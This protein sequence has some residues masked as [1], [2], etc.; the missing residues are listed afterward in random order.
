MG[1]SVRYSSELS[2]HEDDEAQ[3]GAAEMRLPVAQRSPSD[4]L[5]PGRVGA[6]GPT[7]RHVVRLGS[8]S[9]QR[10]NLK[11]GADRME[12]APVRD[13]PPVLRSGAAAH[14]GSFQLRLL[15]FRACVQ[16]PQ[17]RNGLFGHR[18]RRRCRVWDSS[19]HL[20][21]SSWD[22]SFKARGRDTRWLFGNCVH[23]QSGAISVRRHAPVCTSRA[24]LEEGLDVL[25]GRPGLRARRRQ[26]FAE[27]STS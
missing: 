13:R 26:L 15:R 11:Q 20:G 25:G 7:A 9:W 19:L 12:G 4:P 8:L 3:P 24:V 16:L 21:R 10:G 27:S 22:E 18:Q 6:D 5:R 2:L 14:Q 23:N 1:G 17:D